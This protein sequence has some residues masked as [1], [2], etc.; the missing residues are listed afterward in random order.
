MQP[1]IG[2]FQLKI[3]E[4]MVGND[5]KAWD[6][7]VLKSN[8]SSFYHQ[9]G[10]KRVV[11]K[12]YGYKPI[13]LLVKEGDEIRGVLPMFLIKSRFFGKKLV[14]VP[15][16]PYGGVCSDNILATEMLIKEAKRIVDR[17]NLDYLELR[18]FVKCNNNGFITNESYVTF[19]VNLSPDFNNNFSLISAGRVILPLSS[20]STFPILYPIPT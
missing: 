18:N 20:I 6:E 3:Q 2:M 1:K 13:Y 15:F 4:M 16:G 19:I 10:W 5:E 12:T 11:E 17:E 8:Y 9:I 7:Y 14:S